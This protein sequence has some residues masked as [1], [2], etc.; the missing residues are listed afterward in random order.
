MEKEVLQVCLNILPPWN[1]ALTRID[2]LKYLTGRG[3][4]VPAD[5]GQYG[6]VPSAV[7]VSFFNT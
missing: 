4:K 1:P 5:D 3:K 6:K 2:P 7:L